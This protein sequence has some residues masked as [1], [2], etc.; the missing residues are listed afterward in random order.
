MDMHKTRP[1]QITSGQWQ[2]SWRITQYEIELA[3]ST[4]RA[5]RQLCMW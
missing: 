1:L 5:D 3:K 4:D 2:N